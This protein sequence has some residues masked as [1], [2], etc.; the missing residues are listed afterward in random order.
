MVRSRKGF[1]Y[2]LIHSPAEFKIRVFF[3]LFFLEMAAYT[4]LFYYLYPIL[5]GK[6]ITWPKS[7]LFVLETITTTGYG[8]LMPFQNDLTVIFTIIMMITGITIIFT[9]VPLLIAPYLSSILQTSPPQ[10]TPH[11]LKDHVV[12][13]GY[14]ELATSLIE[15]L[16][17]SDLEIVIIDD[18]EH[19]IIE[20]AK[21]HRN[22]VFT[23]WGD[24]SNPATWSG[25]WL[26]YASN[27]IVC[28]DER[29]AATIILGIREQTPGRIIA[30]V[31]KLS[32][33]RYLRDAGAEYVL[34][35]KHVTGRMLARHAELTAHHTVPIDLSGSDQILLDS[36]SSY[37]GILRIIHIPIMP[38]T[39]AAGKTLQELD[40]IN[41]YGFYT[42]FLA[43]GGK[44]VFHPGDDE[45]IDY[46]SGLFLIGR[47]DKIPEM[48]EN[49]FVSG[50]TGKNIAV[51][52]GFGD[53]GR[54][55][56]QDLTSRGISCIVIDQ[57]KQKAE[58]VVG[59]A[60]DE[61]VLLEA[62]ISEARYCLIALNDDDINIF[63]T[64]M[65]RDMNPA[66]RI[67]ARANEPVSVE[68]LYRAGADY[69]ALLPSIGGQVIGRVVLSDIVQVILDLP[70][71]HK[72][73]RKHMM[74]NSGMNIGW[75]EK[76]T[77]AM[78][79]GMEGGSRAIVKP[80]PEEVMMEGD[81][82]IATGTIDQLKKFIRLC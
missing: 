31:D 39:K 69:V 52:A 68:K 71:D 50:D 10:K 42:L 55:A 47:I 26:K 73:V 65:A 37:E 14:G 30:V 79:I 60:E 56:Y 35:P 48:V 16:M 11:K 53:V 46:S 77:G 1:L 6:S 54:A 22:R 13:I 76:K 75:L 4:I 43:R 70:F 62:N 59:N 67:L 2:R 28:E 17:I 20:V 81:F 15:S 24:Y 44:F 34:S 5:E 38:G 66:I 18:D 32:F 9:I 25:G 64:L 78:I 80:R 7:L 57:K 21:K 3:L 41:R 58:G 82:L 63:T 61:D 27:V 72:V 12:I 49:E 23:V 74:K 40:L 29:T 8:E 36:I 45:L 33:D 19:T 51:I